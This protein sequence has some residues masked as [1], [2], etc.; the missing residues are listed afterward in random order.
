[1][2][3][4]EQRDHRET[5]PERGRRIA[6]ESLREQQRRAAHYAQQAEIARRL[7]ERLRGR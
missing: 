3:R 1:M 5:E 2:S 6:E 7:A 4:R